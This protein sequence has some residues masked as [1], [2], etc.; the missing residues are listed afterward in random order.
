MFVIGD[1]AENRM[2]EGKKGEPAHKCGLADSG[3]AE[4][5]GMPA[6]VS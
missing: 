1:L 4:E 6:M 3:L 5:I 2:G